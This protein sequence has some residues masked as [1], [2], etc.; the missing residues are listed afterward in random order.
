MSSNVNIQEYYKN[1]KLKMRPGKMNLRD[2]LCQAAKQHL[3]DDAVMIFLNWGFNVAKKKKEL[4]FKS[5]ESYPFLLFYY[6]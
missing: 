5:G 6:M 3:S 1:I 4:F 2:L